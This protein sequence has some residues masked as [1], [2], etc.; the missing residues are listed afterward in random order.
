MD[1]HQLSGTEVIKRLGTDMQRGLTAGEARRRLGE[2]GKNELRQEKKQGIVS[3]FIN[4]FKDLMIIILLAAAGISMTLSMINGDREY[5]DSII[6]L[7]IVVC[8]AVIGVVQEL[9]A[10]NAIEALKKMSSPHA[11]VIRDGT[12]LRIDSCDVVPGDIVAIRTGDLVPADLRLLRS[13]GIKT[14]ESA[15]TGES[16]PVDK[17]ENH[18]SSE[19]E[20]IGEQAGMLFA[21]CG[22]ASGSGIAV[23][24]ATAMDTAM[25]RIAKMLDQ[26]EAPLTPLQV[27]LKQLSKMLGLGVVAICAVIFLLGMLQKVEPLEMF[28]IAIS[29]AVAAIPEGMVAVVTI[30]LAIGIKRMAQKRAIVRHMPVVETLGS[31][32]VICSDKTGTL[33]QNKMTVVKYMSA[34]GQREISSNDAQFALELCSLCNNSEL[35]SNR[36]LGDPT[37]TALIRA[38]KGDRTQLEREYPRTG[39]IPFNSKRKRMT[40]AH[41]TAHGARIIT[42]GAP[43]ILLPLC[44]FYLSGTEILPMTAGVKSRLAA[45]NE[46]LANGALRVLAV[47]YKD[48][49]SPSSSDRENE[50]SLVFCGM[51]AMEDP[52][53]K[54][55]KQAVS[56]CKNAGIIPV[57]ITGDHAATAMAIARRLGIAQENSRVITGVQL[58]GMKGREQTEEIINCRV[59]ARVSPE[60]KVVIVRAFQSQGM[61]VAMTG[62]GVNDAPALKSADIGCAMGKNGTEVAQSAADMILTDDDFSTIVAAVREGRGIYKNIRKTIHFLV[63]CNIGEILLIFVAF[64]LGIPTPLLAIQLLWVNLVTDS[65]PALALGADPISEDIMKEVPNKK[66]DGI[67]AKGM[68]ASVLV[69]G[70]LIGALALLAYVIGRTQFDIDPLNP[71][72]GRTMSFAVLS[73]SQLVHSFNMRSD[74]SVFQAG[75]LSNRQLLVS[76]LICGLL[77]AAVITLPVLTAVFKT[78][79]LNLLQWLIV[80]LLSL[81]P[82]AVV[83]LE[84]TIAGRGKKN[85]FSSKDPD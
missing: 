39:E 43:D 42:K 72:I 47:A 5:I 13:V 59:F 22:V 24:T 29:L 83:E 60:H 77:M 56:Q 64:L 85:T 67:F 6:I 66:S 63:S 30:V 32:Q 41:R 23:V 80:A 3:R 50:S 75:L 79:A 48:V 68:G 61:V 44:S 74:H 57:M 73:F 62:D 35:V 36:L 69:E 11:V 20:G 27:K 9:R 76:V 53:R 4:Q 40:T 38:W 16:L 17:D 1:F 33:T 78:T 15:L 51:V 81:I 52:P 7:V 71:A 8:N 46:Q 26:E 10:D 55:V 12:K 58:D 49:Q 31:T 34:T 28:M 21:G 19:K 37:E 25:G 45:E 54:G 82:L 70:C 2:F 65:L 14:E 84:K 18:I